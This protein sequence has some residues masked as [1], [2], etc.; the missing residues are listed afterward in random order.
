MDWNNINGYHRG[1]NQVDRGQYSKVYTNNAFLSGCCLLIS[2]TVIDHLGLFDDKYYMYLEDADF[3]QKALNNGYHLAVVP[4]SIIWHLNAGSSGVGGPLQD[5]FLSRN[6]LLFGF[7]YASFRTKFALIRQ[8][9]V[10]LILSPYPW[11][12]K[13]IRDYYL[14]KF[15]KGSWR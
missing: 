11:Q 6:R 9:F 2:A 4:Q 1:V 15:G 7:R 8:S 13:G 10:K 14:G 5:Y 3:C 12:K